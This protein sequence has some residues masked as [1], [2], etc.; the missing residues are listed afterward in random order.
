MPYEQKDMSGSLFANK[1]KKNE[2]SPDY[3]G[4]A[5][6]EGKEYRIAGWKKGQGAK[7]FLSLAFSEKSDAGAK[8]AARED[9]SDLESD[10]PF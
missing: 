8:K 9:L 7:T 4:T 2:R 3:S 5:L 1:E 6:I 10:I